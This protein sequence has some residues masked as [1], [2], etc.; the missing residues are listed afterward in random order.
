MSRFVLPFFVALVGLTPAVAA[1][2]PAGPDAKPPTDLPV[3]A[4]TMVVVHLNGID[5]TRE[6]L[7][8]MLT[9]V[10]ADFAKQTAKQLD[11]VLKSAL[12]GR[13]LKAIDGT[14]RVYLAVGHLTQLSGP[15]AAVAVCLPVADYKAFR[16]KFLTAGERRSSE[17][18]KDGV[19]T[20]TTADT[21][22][23][24][25]LVNKD[26]Y[27]TVTPNKALAEQYAGKFDRLSVKALAKSADALLG[28]DVSVFVN[29][30][31]VNALYAAEIAQGKQLFNLILQQGAQGLDKQQ[32]E[33]TKTMFEA[34][35]QM[36]EDGRGLVLGIDLRPEGVALRVDARFAPDTATGKLVAAERPTV[37]A[38]LGEMPKG[39]MSYTATK[40]KL[41]LGKLSREFVAAPDEEKSADAIA[42]LEKM[43]T[44]GGTD[45]V[46]VSADMRTSLTLRTVAGADKATAALLKVLKGL[47]A[48]SSYSNV[49]LKGRPDVTEKAETHKGFTLHRAELKMDFEATAEKMPNEE[50]RAAAVA[51]MKRLSPEKVTQWFGSDGKRLVTVVA[52][53][54]KAA[55]GLLDAVLDK[56]ATAAADARFAATRKQLPPTAGTVMLFDAVKSL[57]FVGGFLEG[58]KLALPDLPVE[59]PKFDQVTGDPVYLGVAVGL[60]GDTARVDAFV[61]VG[62]VKLVRQVFAGK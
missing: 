35:F 32:L 34:I 10:G 4:E 48:G 42:A 38:A 36:V 12:E 46:S 58:M 8:K 44:D 25:H 60:S 9:G 52:P 61:P 7:S 15:D 51:S 24:V 30:T 27:V 17:I 23:T 54:W 40:W 14:G 41:N 45:S 31:Q 49:L 59:L 37:L 13:D 18:G 26:G 55:K 5:R 20:F 6:R 33:T 53:D 62:V 19:D 39:M 47:T 16:Q 2:V 57:A 3:P 43:L 29:L 56:T 22:Q 1:P 11:D 50:Q 28:S 21:D